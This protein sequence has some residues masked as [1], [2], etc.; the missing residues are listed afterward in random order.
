M[1][2]FNI[3]MKLDT[4]AD[5]R[6]VDPLIV[7]RGRDPMSDELRLRSPGAQGSTVQVMPE[8]LKE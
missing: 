6:S 3:T 7:P 5:V 4:E 8:G 1:Q 2:K